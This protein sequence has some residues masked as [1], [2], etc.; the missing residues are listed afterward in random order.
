[1]KAI[2]HLAVQLSQLRGDSPVAPSN[3]R[4]SKLGKFPLIDDT[5]KLV[6]TS[7]NDDTCHQKLPY[8][9]P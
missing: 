2:I 5:L 8:R 1:M 3:S 7:K 6:K 4:T 9:L